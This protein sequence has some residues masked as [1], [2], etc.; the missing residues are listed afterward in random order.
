VIEKGF[1]GQL[2]GADL[3]WLFPVKL[4]NQG[5]FE[6]CKKRVDNDNLFAAFIPE[7]LGQVALCIGDPEHG[8]EGE[9]DDANENVDKV[10]GDSEQDTLPKRDRAV[11]LGRTMHLFARNLSFLL[12]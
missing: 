2:V 10:L 5:L 11:V 4:S 9:E 6:L 3:Q 7:E 1:G 8:R 12:H